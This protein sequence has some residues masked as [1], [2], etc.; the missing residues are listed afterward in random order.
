MPDST[1][2]GATPPPEFPPPVTGGPA[3]PKKEKRV[4]AFDT[5]ESQRR[6]QAVRDFARAKV[7][8]AERL[9]R[10]KLQPVGRAATGEMRRLGWKKFGLYAVGAAALLAL[11]ALAVQ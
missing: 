2:L 10:E 5:E 4:G 7:S 8:P 3:A 11:V 1:S 9:A 6:E